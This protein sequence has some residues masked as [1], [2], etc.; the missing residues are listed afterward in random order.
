MNHRNFYSLTSLF[1]G[2]FALSGVASGAIAMGVATETNVALNKP[3]FGDT[4]FGAPTS[5]GNDGIDGNADSGNW[6]HANYPT[7]AVP[8][9]GEAVNAPNPYWEVDLQGSYNLTSFDVTDRV[10]C[11]GPVSRLDGSMV[12]LIGA[13]G[14]IVGT[15]ALTG[16]VGGGD[17]SL[18]CL[19]F[20]S[21]GK[22]QVGIAGRGN[23][24]RL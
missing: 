6:T 21:A 13:G 9:P 18:G 22:C 3:T 5:R 11:C 23:E 10:G 16:L 20:G 15:Q 19:L 8:Y 4:A 7:S 1:G 12:T 24:C 2:A 14:S 17:R